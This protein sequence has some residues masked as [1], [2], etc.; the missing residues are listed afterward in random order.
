[1][2]KLAKKP[3]QTNLLGIFSGGRR[4]QNGQHLINLCMIHDLLITNTFQTQKE[5]INKMGTNS[6]CTR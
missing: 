3:T 2:E 1:M 6:S 4:N 5:K